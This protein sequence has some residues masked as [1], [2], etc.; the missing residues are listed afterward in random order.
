MNG[1]LRNLGMI[2]YGD[3]SIVAQAKWDKDKRAIFLPFGS[4]IRSFMFRKDQIPL[5]LKLRRELTSNF[6]FQTRMFC[7]VSRSD[8]SCG[9]ILIF[10]PILQHNSLYICLRV[11]RTVNKP[12]KCL[13]IKLERGKLLMCLCKASGEKP[14]SSWDVTFLLIN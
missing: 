13:S 7:D 12:S 11:L 10:N 2:S 1:K 6:K 14:V 5:W 8:S 9:I 4:L 3:T